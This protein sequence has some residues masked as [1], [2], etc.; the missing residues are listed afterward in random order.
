MCILRLYVV[1][2]DGKSCE[3]SSSR[4]NN[5]E[6]T[7]ILFNVTLQPLFCHSQRKWFDPKRFLFCHVQVV[8]NKGE[9]S[10]A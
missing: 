2:V 9:T 1:Y 8:S 5:N 6:K 7:G 3:E 10:G 4:S